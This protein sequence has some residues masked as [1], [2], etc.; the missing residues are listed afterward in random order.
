MLL[1]A[2]A[3]QLAFAGVMSL[4]APA[5]VKA[6]ETHL[7]TEESKL[8]SASAAVTTPSGEDERGV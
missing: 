4:F 3:A 6:V 1:H 7:S 5:S 8:Q 2:M